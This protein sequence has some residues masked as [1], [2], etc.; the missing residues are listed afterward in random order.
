MSTN[1]PRPEVT[2][3]SNVVTITDESNTITNIIFIPAW[4]HFSVNHTTQ[5]LRS[6]GRTR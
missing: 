3:R 6:R 4:L 5:R 1:N 2:S